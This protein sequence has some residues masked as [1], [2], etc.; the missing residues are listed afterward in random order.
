MT[1]RYP[2]SRA[3]KRIESIQRETIDLD[4]FKRVIDKLIYFFNSQWEMLANYQ[5]LQ[6]EMII[7]IY[8]KYFYC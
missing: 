7:D 5:E 3:P 8:S 1:F 2:V 6:D 4:N